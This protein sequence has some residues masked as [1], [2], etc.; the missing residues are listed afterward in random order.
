LKFADV[1]A[2][3][4]A[5]RFGTP[6][7]VLSGPDMRAAIREFVAADPEARISYASK[8]NGALSVLRIARDEGID[9][10]VASEGE[11]EGGIRAGFEPRQ[12]TLHGSNKSDSELKR[13][14]ELG[15]AAVVLDH[16][17]EI[18][19]LGAFAKKTV[20]VMIRLAPGVDP[21][22][23][24]AISTGQA[25]T[26]FG[27]GILD[28]SANQALKSVLDHP[29]LSLTGLHVHVGSQLMN[30]DAHTDA[31][32][33]MA[34]FAISRDLDLEELC[35]G[36]GIGIRYTASE[37]PESF[38]EH[39]GRIKRTL[40]SAY[41]SRQLPRLSYEPGRALVGE[42]GTTLY[43]VGAIK[44]TP[45]RKYLSVDGGMADNL[46]PQLY[47]ASYVA[48][49]ADR[50]SEPH[51]TG[52]RISGR[53]CETDTLISEAFLPA[54]TSEG[55]LIAVQCTGAYNFSMASNYNRYP[56]PAMAIVG[57]ADPFLAV[58]RETIA[59]LFAQE[60]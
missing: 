10:D 58:R 4:L 12:I 15:V 33:K 56:R 50:L 37:K 42:A 2:A 28:G 38:A 21:E 3:E 59:D 53:H 31:I 30:S 35:V 52:F 20:N 27:F 14:A 49:N 41:G 51:D 40:V 9:V 11:L 45:F 25:D 60:L 34:D 5:D 46:R 17:S 39:C 48:M 32:K 57:E 18:E 47:G 43:R 29:N 19:R 44:E 55:D 22:T 26:K 54:T 6:L 24:E 16:I 8:A 13:A 23:H 1:P 7:Y 36:G